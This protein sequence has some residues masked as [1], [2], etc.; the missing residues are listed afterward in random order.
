M[1]YCIPAV[2]R[3]S[4]KTDKNQNIYDNAT[5]LS[6]EMEKELPQLPVVDGQAWNLAKNWQS[7]PTSLVSMNLPSILKKRRD[8][9]K[10]K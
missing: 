4:G 6:D 10:K 7:Q 8:N 5:I 1:R 9:S 3:K 2:I